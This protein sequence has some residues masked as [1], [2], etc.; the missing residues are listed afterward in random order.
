[1]LSWDQQE[2]SLQLVE[3]DLEKAIASLKSGQP[4]IPLWLDRI[5][6]QVASRLGR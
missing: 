5:H 4:V 2:R 1:M 6:Q 3:F